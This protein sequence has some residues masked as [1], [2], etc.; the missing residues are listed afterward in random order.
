MSNT[1]SVI[2]NTSQIVAAPLLTVSNPFSAS[3]SVSMMIGNLSY[4]LNP[5]V[6]G[7]ANNF[8]QGTVQGDT[9]RT[10]SHSTKFF[11]GTVGVADQSTGKVGIGTT[12]PFAL[13][14]IATPNGAS[15]SL[16]TL[17]AIASSTA[18]GATTTFFSVT[19]T[20][21]VNIGNTNY[22]S[23]V[24]VQAP[25]GKGAFRLDVT[26]PNQPALSIGGYGTLSVDYPNIGGGR[27]VLK[28]GTA[29]NFGIGTSSP[30][31]KLS[32]ATIPNTMGATTLG[33][34]YWTWAISRTSHW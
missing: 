21:N 24:S 25:A 7:A 33:F 3:A 4:T 2:I 20:G 31:A 18:A 5:F 29:S 15:G 19:N 34:G 10:W 27:L 17:F 22:G 1:G 23:T 28:D 14:S 26:T 32:I 12:S 13:L 6:S 16:G 9:G 11:F 30:Y 8:L